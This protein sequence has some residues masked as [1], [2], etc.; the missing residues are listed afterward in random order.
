MRKTSF[1][2]SDLA[3]VFTFALVYLED[4]KAGGAEEKRA[5]RCADADDRGWQHGC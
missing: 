3:V 1:D 5:N 2:L 4:N